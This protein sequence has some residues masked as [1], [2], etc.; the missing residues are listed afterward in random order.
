[1]S[2]SLTIQPGTPPPGFSRGYATRDNDGTARDADKPRRGRPKLAIGDTAHGLVAQAETIE[3][4]V[5]DEILASGPDWDDQKRITVRLLGDARQAAGS[6]TTPIGVPMLDVFWG[7]EIAMMADGPPS[8]SEM[9]LPNYGRKFMPNGDVWLRYVGAYVGDARGSETRVVDPNKRARRVF[10]FGDAT[11]LRFGATATSTDAAVYH[12]KFGSVYFGCVCIAARVV[13]YIGKRSDLV[14][15]PN[16]N[17]DAPENYSIDGTATMF[18]QM[19]TD[20]DDPTTHWV[21]GRGEADLLRNT[22]IH[23][24]GSGN[25]TRHDLQ[26]GRP[27]N[28]PWSAMTP[29]TGKDSDVREDHVFFGGA[30]YM[31]N[32]I[33]IQDSTNSL[34]L[35]ESDSRGGVH[36]AHLVQKEAGVK[37]WD[38]ANIGTKDFFDDRLND[39]GIVAGGTPGG[40]MHHHHSYISVVNDGGIDKI[41]L[42]AINSDGPEYQGIS[43]RLLNKAFDPDNVDA[44]FMTAFESPSSGANGEW[45]NEAEGDPATSGDERIYLTG[46]HP[47]NLPESPHNQ[48]IRCIPGRSKY[49]TRLYSDD[50]MPLVYELEW[51][52]A[53]EPPKTRLLY[54]PTAPV[55]VFSFGAIQERP[56]TNNSPIAVMS[57]VPADFGGLSPG[58]GDRHLILSNDGQTYGVVTSPITDIPNNVSESWHYGTGNH[59]LVSSIDG[60]RKVTLPTIKTITPIPLARGIDNLLQT[61]A[62]WSEGTGADGNAQVTALTR[63]GS[64]LFEDNGDVLPRDP[65]ESAHAMRFKGTG[66]LRRNPFGNDKRTS[67]YVGSTDDDNG[68]ANLVEDVDSQLTYVVNLLQPTVDWPGVPAGNRTR[69]LSQAWAGGTSFNN[70]GFYAQPFTDFAGGQSHVM[71]ATL[72]EEWQTFAFSHPF[73]RP[74]TTSNTGD[75]VGINDMSVLPRLEAP[76]VGPDRFFDTYI[77]FEHV[78]QGRGWPGPPTAPQT[79]RTGDPETITLG[80]DFADGDVLFGV[81]FCSERVH[82][83]M[84]PQYTAVEA[85]AETRPDGNNPPNDVAIRAPAEQLTDSNNNVVYNDFDIYNL[86]VAES[87]FVVFEA[88]DPANDQNWL[89]ASIVARTQPEVDGGDTFRPPLIRLRGEKGGNPFDGE[90]EWSNVDGIGPYIFAGRQITARLEQDA[91]NG[92]SFKC[93]SQG[94]QA[95]VQVSGL[96]GQPTMPIKQVGADISDSE[97]AMELE[98]GLLQRVSASEYVGDEQAFARLDG[99]PAAVAEGGRRRSAFARSMIQPELIA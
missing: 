35:V 16:T 15:V 52:D 36:I 26:P 18:W 1:M 25:K 29:S 2:D 5:V 70:N 7:D 99:L 61:D 28:K 90:V 10:D 83:Q 6:S 50:D 71:R 56:G 24:P 65:G 89:I 96:A 44:A 39:E 33:E 68:G 27:R 43:A 41:Y 93:S 55:P 13:R 64:G 57:Q 59:I 21:L 86:F 81:M 80:W 74:G 98:L 3:P 34:S 9:I 67:P 85:D 88:G 38:F 75:T 82:P 19:P 87:E 58:T 46:S 4:G 73:G 76:D 11:G 48:N 91:V 8:G 47:D 49:I 63:N 37:R 54:G 45:V 22:D 84:F 77:N 78:F 30:D 20:L 69:M 95:E 14:N 23:D 32:G 60:L 31:A 66:A 51:T 12:P 40:G 97:K 17:D 94:I 92:P 53:S 72:T 42:M 79:D 62:S